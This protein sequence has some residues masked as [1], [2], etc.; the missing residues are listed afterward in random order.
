MNRYRVGAGARSKSVNVTQMFLHDHFGSV[1]A[2][3]NYFL[4]DITVGKRR[5]VDS[6]VHT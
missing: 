4:L 6:F 3:P 2:K 1:K 5:I